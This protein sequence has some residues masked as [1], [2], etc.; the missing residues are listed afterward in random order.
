MSAD[1]KITAWFGG[2]ERQ[3]LC[4]R[5]ELRK[6]QDA[7]KSGI[8]TVANRLAAAAVVMMANPEASILQV[9]AQ[10]IG[11]I[12]ESDVR[13]TIFHCLVAGG[14]NPNVAGKL[15]KEWIDD[16]GL[17]GLFENIP[18][19]AEILIVGVEAPAEEGES[20][21]GAA[22]GQTASTSSATTETPPKSSAGRRAKPTP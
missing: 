20:E 10:G 21:P 1:G 13:D 2:E 22:P 6:I 8:F 9:L 7:S 16:R 18:L 4:R 3:F 15:V 11:D 17:K 19:A 14:E 5:A 12:R